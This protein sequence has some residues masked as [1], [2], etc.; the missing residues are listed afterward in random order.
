MSGDEVYELYI[1]A[2]TPATIPMARLSEYMADF[3]EL[4]GHEAHVH[5]E[6]V[7]PRSPR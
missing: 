5:F 1:D 3:A 2:L 7:K 4:L 6:R